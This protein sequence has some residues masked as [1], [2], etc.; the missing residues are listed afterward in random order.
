MAALGRRRWIVNADDFGVSASVNAAVR[1]AHDRGVLTSASLLVNGAGFE[2]AV[3]IARARPGLGVGLHL[4]LVQS[5]ATLPAARIPGLVDWRGRFPESG[6]RTGWRYWQDRRL[7]PELEA[8]IGAQFERFHSTG[9]TLDHLDGHLNL[10]LHPVV[11]DLLMVNRDRWRIRHMRLVRD[12]LRHNLRLASGRLLSRVLLATAFGALARRAAPRLAAAGIRHPD[13][14]YGLL[15]SGRVDEPY[16]LRLLATLPEGDHELYCH[17][18]LAPPRTEFEA[19]VSPL[20]RQA[21]V[22]KGVTLIR[23]QDL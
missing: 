3:E 14:V 5:A 6:F 15:Q 11:F 19:L 17:P 23:Y 13:S 9:L 12:P 16:L 18:D 22:D 1:D 10:H 21:L 4:A 7:R 8:E 20:V 2:E